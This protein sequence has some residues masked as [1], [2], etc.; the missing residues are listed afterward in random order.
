MLGLVPGSGSKALDYDVKNQAQDCILIRETN[1]G[2]NSEEFGR[3]I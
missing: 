1:L 2:I 3:F